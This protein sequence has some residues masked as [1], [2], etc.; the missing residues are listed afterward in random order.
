MQVSSG[1]RPP[2]GKMMDQDGAGGGNPDN[3]STRASAAEKNRLLAAEKIKAAFKAAKAI[4][5]GSA[6][7]TGAA[8]P[9]PQAPLSQDNVPNP[10]PKSG[11]TF[12][13]SHEGSANGASSLPPP[14]SGRYNAIM[15]NRG[16]KFKPTSLGETYSGMPLE[17]GSFCH[18]TDYRVHRAV[19][20]DRQIC[21][22][23][24]A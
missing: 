8:T 21:Q 10:P 20:F 6:P 19:V 23:L 13:L 16:I 15:I 3:T 12:S 7:T 17:C 22:F 24:Q 5:T 14:P 9:S 11:S 4:S 1:S 18:E 2:W